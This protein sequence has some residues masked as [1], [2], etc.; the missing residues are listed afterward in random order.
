MKYL[1]LV[2]GSDTTP[3]KK[4]SPIPIQYA[5]NKLGLKPESAIIVGDSNFDIEAGKA[6]GVKTIAVTYGYKP[7]EMLKGAD[8]MIDNMN[9]LPEALGMD[10][11]TS[12]ERPV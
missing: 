3:E 11:F 10:I 1:D 12:L 2:V 7:K 8:F 4:P 9:K 6:A 5:L